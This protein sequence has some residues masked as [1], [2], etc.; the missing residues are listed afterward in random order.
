[1]TS[2]KARELQ[3]KRQKIQSDTQARNP[4]HYIRSKITFFMF[5]IYIYFHL[6]RDTNY[7]YVKQD[8]S[9]SYVLYHRL[10]TSADVLNFKINNNLI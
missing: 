10:I 5:E 1:M 2:F 4:G 3:W 9:L 6:G 7:A 8:Y